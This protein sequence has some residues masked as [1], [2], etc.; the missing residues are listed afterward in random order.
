MRYSSIDLMRT[1][2]I[3]VMVMVHFGENLAGYIPPITGFGAPLFAFLSGM[4]YRLWVNG[5]E[6]RQRSPEEISKVSVRRGLFVFGIGIAFNVLV[7]L[8]EDVFNWDVLTFIGTALLI[9][10]LVRQQPAPLLLFMAFLSLFFA[11]VFR[12]LVDYNAYWTNNYFDYDFTLSDVLIGYLVTGYFP[13][14]PWIT[15]SLVGFLLA[16]WMFPPSGQP[17]PNVRGV[18]LSGTALVLLSGLAVWTHPTTST[19][20][21]KIFWLGW[22]MYPPTTEYVAGTLGM[23]MVLFGTLHAC[24]DRNPRISEN[25]V[26]LGIAMACSRNAF[27]IYLLHHLV[28]VWPMWVYG[29]AMGQNP[30]YY[31]KQ[32]LPASTALLLAGLFLALM[33]FILWRVGPD[34]NHGIERWMR[35]LCD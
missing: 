12:Y 20:M 1:I 9:L 23:A 25:N 2:A 29:L 13:L 18:L 11:P 7:W 33:F 30:D 17:A 6:A 19:A 35:W 32:L 14:F 22:K 27:T 8:P 15:Y 26:V 4:S 28:H 31:W 34:R 5:Q 10:N 21:T 24:V 16:G 3:C